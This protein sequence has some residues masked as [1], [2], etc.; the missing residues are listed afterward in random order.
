MTLRRLS[1]DRLTVSGSAARSRT[2]SEQVA[3]KPMPL[4]ASGEMAASAIAA[5]T[6]ATH[7]VQMS[8][9]DCSTISPGSC[10]TAIGRRA[11]ANRAPVWSNTPARALEVPTSTPIKACRIRTPLKS[12]ASPS[13]SSLPACIAA[14]DQNDASGHQ[15]GGFGGQEQDHGGDLVHLSEPRHR[16]AADPGIEH[17]RV[18]LCKGV[19]R[20][21]DV[22][23]RD[24]IDAHPAGAP[25]RGE[26]LRQMVHRSLRGV[27]IA[28]LLR[29]VD[30]EARHRADVD[31]SSRLRG[32]HMRTEGAAA[33]EGAVEIDVD[34]IEPVLVG[35]G[36]GRRL[37]ASDAGVVDEN[38]DF[39]IA[40]HQL[41]GRLRD[42]GRI[43]DVH[44]DDTGIVA[45][46]LE[47][48]A[49]LLGSVGI[50]IRDQDRRARLRQ[51]FG[52]GKPDPL[53]GTGH[54]G[55]LAVKPEFFQIHLVFPACS[56][57]AWMT[58]KVRRSALAADVMAVWRPTSGS[59]RQPLTSLRPNRCAI[60]SEAMYPRRIRRQPHRVTCRQVEFSDVAYRERTELF[61]VDVKKRIAAEV[62]SDRHSPRPALFL[63]IDPQVFGPDA[64][65]GSAVLPR[66]IPRDKVHLRGTDKSRDEDIGR[67]FIQFQRRAILLDLAR[68][69]HH[70]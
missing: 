42:R 40:G 69:D 61:G 37:A 36:F 49:P 39:S 1:P 32:K 17:R 46:R 41:I 45:L 11:V 63:A 65:G 35:D 31:D 54:D 23:R 52:A 21:F 62:L 30:D 5:R 64:D 13:G 60:L 58:P 10:Q 14:I 20:R 9:D 15:A 47:G 4:T 12:G 16:R 43:R 19:Q 44:D 27:V 50:A 51:R 29:L 28:L 7:A 56:F 8:E 66:H 67:P 6:E 22:G 25:L 38:V 33:P 18:A 26:R 55:G 59:T 48:G 34:D 2:T 57:S 53:S 24:R 70:D 3:S 68:V